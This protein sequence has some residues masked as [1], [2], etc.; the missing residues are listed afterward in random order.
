[1][2]QDE[3]STPHHCPPHNHHVR[4][5][6]I[7]RSTSTAFDLFQMIPTTSIPA[8]ARTSRPTVSCTP[9]MVTLGMSFLP[10]YDP[11]KAA[12]VL[13]SNRGPCSCAVV[14]RSRVT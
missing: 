13:A 14:T 4:K 2:E 12:K 6:P 7:M 3:G 9:R 11:M 1:M 5:M 10:H 8:M